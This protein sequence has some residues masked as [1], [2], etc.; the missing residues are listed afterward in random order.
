[1]QQA[2]RA[3][4]AFFMDGPRPL[5]AVGD[6][7]LKRQIS[8][9]IERAS[10][11]DALLQSPF[12]PAIPRRHQRRLVILSSHELTRYKAKNPLRLNRL[13]RRACLVVV[14][15][16]QEARK[17]LEA[18]QVADGLVFR[19]VNLHRLPLIAGLA[20]SGYVAIP[21]PLASQLVNRGLRRELLQSLSGIERRVLAM[22]GSGSSNRMIGATLDIDEGRTKYLIRS[23][24]KKLHLQNRTQA[25]VF[26]RDTL[27]GDAEAGPATMKGS[28]AGKGASF[29]Q[30]LARLFS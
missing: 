15:Q 8:L 5:V 13:K 9:A 29:S 26:A 1:M 7:Q 24:F 10:H 14:V 22:L 2:E 17:I 27:G 19:E 6:R 18:I 4:R 28:E 3:R 23:V 16:H 25:A 30:H 12:L 20:E 11:S 21:S